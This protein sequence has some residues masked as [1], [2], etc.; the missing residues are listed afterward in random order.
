MSTLLKCADRCADRKSF[1]PTV[2]LTMRRPCSDRAD[3]C[4]DHTAG[5]GVVPTGLHPANGAFS[6]SMVLIT[7]ACGTVWQPRTASQ[8]APDRLSRVPAILR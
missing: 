4:A 3:R 5:R 6:Q 7:R 2:V 1:A 8:N